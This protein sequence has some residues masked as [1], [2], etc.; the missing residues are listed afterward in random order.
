M[1]AFKRLKIAFDV[2][3]TLSETVVQN[4][5]H[6]LDRKRCEL[7]VWS[8]LGTAYAQSFCEENNLKPDRIIEKQSEVVDV[9]L[10]DIPESIYKAHITLG[11]TN[12]NL[13]EAV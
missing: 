9:A 2:N 7:I 3:N 12:N 10:D 5:Y 13:K 8:S 4:L 1:K 6:A 11:V